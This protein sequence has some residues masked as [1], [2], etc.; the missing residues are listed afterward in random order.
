MWRIASLFLLQRNMSS[1]LISCLCIF[2]MYFPL[3]ILFFHF[4]FKISLHFAFV[5]CIP[6]CFASFIP[7][8]WFK[9]SKNFAADLNIEFIFGC[10]LS[11]TL[12]MLTNWSSLYFVL[13]YSA[14]LIISALYAASICN[15]PLPPSFLFT[16]SLCQLLGGAFYT[17]LASFW[18]SCQFVLFLKFSS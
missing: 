15:S 11:W 14:V 3:F 7:L 6:S 2:L 18:L 4:F 13:R 10:M 12:T 9:S 1:S 16:Y 17:L 5:C 8:S